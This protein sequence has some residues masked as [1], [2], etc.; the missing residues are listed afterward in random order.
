MLATTH[1]RIRRTKSDDWFDPILNA[2][3]ELFVDPFLIFKEKN[4]FWKD[5]HARLI[6][7]FDRAFLMVAEGNLDPATLLYKKALALLV[8]KASKELALDIP[9][10]EPL[11]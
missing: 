5:G 8:F 3:T 6:E 1:F 9:Q 7:H 10:R 2:D 4:G 11:V